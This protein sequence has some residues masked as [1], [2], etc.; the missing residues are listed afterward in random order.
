MAEWPEREQ[1]PPLRAEGELA[2]RVADADRDRTITMLREHVVEG[3]LTLDEFS[4]RVGLA[5]EALSLIHISVPH[6][7][8]H[9]LANATLPYTL[10]I[11]GRGW[12]DA[13]RADPA[14]SE[15]VNV[16][17]GRIVYKPVADAHGLPYDPLG[18]ILE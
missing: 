11:A 7:S 1:Q 6:T 16:V 12:K 15:G 2:E 14:L 17:E 9:A 10:S 13:A 8:T 4:E 5:L 18:E 3:R